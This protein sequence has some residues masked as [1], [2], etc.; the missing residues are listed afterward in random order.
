MFR[1]CRVTASQATRRLSNPCH[2]PSRQPYLHHRDANDKPTP[3]P[4]IPPPPR[5]LQNKTCPPKYRIAD[6]S[7]L[8]PAMINITSNSLPWLVKPSTG[9]DLFSKPPEKPT[10]YPYLP[11]DDD[12][13]SV[14]P[15]RIIANRGTEIFV[16]K[17]NEV[18][19][20]DLQDLK[21]RQPASAQEGY[22]QYKVRH[23]FNSI[24]FS[25]ARCFVS[26]FCR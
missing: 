21:A 12:S 15:K 5:S 25:A 24:F 18:R 6:S 9:Y 1:G 22:R 14:G 20:A 4:Q 16:G 3:T 23:F 19:C 13:E 8:A 26:R 17:G 10:T 2:H 11:S 7:F